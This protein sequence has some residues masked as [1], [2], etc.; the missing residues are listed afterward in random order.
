MATDAKERDQDVEA[1]KKDIKQ[2]RQDMA[3][4]TADFKKVVR[5]GAAAGS[6]RAQDQLER[7]YDQFK[8]T[9]GSLLRRGAVV[10]KPAWKRKS[11]IDRSPF[12]W[13]RLLLGYSSV[14]LCLRVETD[15]ATN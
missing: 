9:Y 3:S 13:G 15:A 8:E 1:I 7:L 5:G 11:Q 6:E 10:Q 14:S 4:L 12:Y 2:L